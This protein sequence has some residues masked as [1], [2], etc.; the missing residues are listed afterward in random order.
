MEVDFKKHLDKKILLQAF[1]DMMKA[2]AM[3]N[4]YDEKK[5]ICKYVHSTSR[6]HEAI[7]LATA[8]H[9]QKHDWVSPYYRDE[10]M[11]LGMGYT[12]YQLMLQLLAKADDPF[13]GGRS[14]YSHPSNLDADYPKMIHQSS[15]TGMQAVPTTGIAQGIQYIE[16][17][18]LKSYPTPPVVLCSF[19]DNSITEGEVSEAFQFAA[20][21]QLPVI[22]LVQD[23][24][25]GISV[26]AEEARSQDAYDFIAGFKGIERMRIDGT[27]FTESYTAMKSA[28]DYV[29][30]ERKPI[31]VC[32]K[33]VLIGHHTSGV[34]K[35]MYRPQDDLL[36]H[37]AHDPGKKLWQYL[38]ELGI[39]EEQL[40]DIERSTEI[41]VRED[42]E[43]ALAA[44]DPK[45]E[46]AV[47]HIFAPTPVTEEKGEREPKNGQKIVMVDASIHAIEELMRKHPEALLY[48]QDVGG[49]IGGVFREAVTLEAKF[50]SKRVF[51]TAIQEAY[52]IGSTIGMSAVGLKPIVEV[53]FADYIYPGINQLITEISKSCYL[54]NGKFPVDNII[55]V[56]IGAYGGGGPY[57]SGSVESIL[58][59]I[60]GIKIAYPSN[61]SDF[62]GLFKAAF[63]DPN[64]VIMLEHKGL[65]WSKVPGTDEAKTIEPAE[66]YILPFGKATSILK[67]SEECVNKGKSICIITYGMGIYWAKEAAKSFKGQI[68]IV[69]LR[70]IIPLDEDYIYE[71][72]K[73]HGKCIVLTEEQI[74]NSFAE[75]LSARISKEC[76]KYLDAPVTPLGAA[77]IPAIPINI[78][79]EKEIL[80]TPEKLKESI[81]S[82][83]KW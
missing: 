50:G 25:W 34:R 57:H 44:E 62:K 63:Y 31:L 17:F 9:L 33:T 54:S 26:T 70:T 1:E 81:E 23:N 41:A 66:D 59:N 24:N 8:Y 80:P 42:F 71:V 79:S 72:V 60:K 40:I 51:N 27:S 78:D 65:Y 73:K 30:T 3:A 43:K 69:D 76:F 75:A 64:P 2:R 10:S 13:S 6:G 37:E 11:L 16:H 18:K 58:A 61:A 38:L 19:G 20:L 15:A 49:R 12:P 83:L 5:Q 55:R 28:F 74:Q 67:A 47:K 56:P 4:L 68:E 35:E 45:P 46:D 48:G 7:Q 36:R 77:N 22:F 29:R 32:A 52:I 39:S 21:H 82:L 53:Q 14:Y